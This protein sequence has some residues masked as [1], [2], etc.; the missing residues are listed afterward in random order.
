MEL[1]AQ[2]DLVT[3]VRRQQVRIG[4]AADVAQQRLM[5][6]AAAGV[7]VEPRDICK[8]HPQHA[9]SQR[10]VSRVSCG[11]VGR[12][13]ERHQEISASNRGSRHSLCPRSYARKCIRNYKLMIGEAHMWRA[14]LQKQI[15]EDAL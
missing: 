15:Y 7:P 2:S 1:T 6:D 3:P 12:I 9:G 11:Q 14:G 13:G 5:I 10:K 4:V 8:P